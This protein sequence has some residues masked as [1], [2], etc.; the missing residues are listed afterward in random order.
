MRRQ[1]LREEKISFGDYDT[2]Q[3]PPVAYSDSDTA[4]VDKSQKFALLMDKSAELLGL[5][6]P[7][8]TSGLRPPARQVKAMLGIWKNRGTE[9]FV[10]LYTNKS[11]SCSATAGKTASG[12]ASLWDKNRDESGKL[13][14]EII[15][16]SVE[17][18]ANNPISAHQSGEALDYG[19]KSNPSG[20]IKKLIDYIQQN[21]Y[22]D[23]ELIDERVAGAD[24]E[25]G[26]GAGSHWHITVHNISPSGEKFLTTPNPQPIAESK[27]NV[28]ELLSYLLESSSL[29]NGWATTEKLIDKVGNGPFVQGNKWTFKL[30]PVSKLERIP[31]EEEEDSE[32]AR[33][34]GRPEYIEKLAKL[35]SSGTEMEPAVGW[36]TGKYYT[37]RD[38]N[39]RIA[40]AVTLGAKKIP[41]VVYEVSLQE[42]SVQELLS[43]L[44]E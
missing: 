16:Q 43:Y 17:L 44:L 40:A 24:G 39:H 14:E 25:L 38:G 5:A 20:N 4:I 19:T 2:W 35:I 7:V 21:G 8:I 10:D 22:A 42:T 41:M 13:P 3:D 9:Y 23:F 11:K 31:F 1:Y 6:E 29:T 36:K 26:S 15:Q 28:Q 27:S 30:V 34:S 37:V 32:Y 33:A 12:L 18:V